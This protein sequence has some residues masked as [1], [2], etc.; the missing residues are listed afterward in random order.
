[1]KQVLWPLQ[2]LISSCEKLVRLDLKDAERETNYLHA[3]EQT[4]KKKRQTHIFKKF[5]FL[6]K[7]RSTFPLITILLNVRLSD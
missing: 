2:A 5:N 6:L 3:R 4:G 1:M 7:S